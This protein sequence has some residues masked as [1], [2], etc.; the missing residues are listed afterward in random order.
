MIRDR[1]INVN[2][3]SKAVSHDQRNLQAALKLDEGQ[4]I[5]VLENAITPQSYFRN[6]Q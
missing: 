5:L 1:I 4:R 6:S 3:R 2:A